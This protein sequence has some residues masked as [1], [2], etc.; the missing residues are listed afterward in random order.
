MIIDGGCCVLIG[1]LL[2]ERCDL[3][4]E[5]VI[6]LRECNYRKL[7]ISQL[8]T[9][10]ESVLSGEHEGVTDLQMKMIVVQVLFGLCKVITIELHR[11]VSAN[12][13]NSDLFDQCPCL[14]GSL[15]RGIMLIMQSP[16]SQACKRPPIEIH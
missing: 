8:T 12:Y 1:C 16:M 3:V 9:S 4:D 14:N 10:N 11:K 15:M 6:F 5:K 2:V 13:T 7:L